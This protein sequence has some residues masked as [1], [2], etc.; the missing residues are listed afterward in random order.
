MSNEQGLLSVLIPNALHLLA[1]K[2]ILG[3]DLVKFEKFT[4]VSF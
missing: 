3:L 1:D 4:T 2:T